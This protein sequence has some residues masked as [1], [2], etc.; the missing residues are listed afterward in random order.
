MAAASFNLGLDL[1][2]SARLGREDVGTGGGNAGDGRSDGRGGEVS[3]ALFRA[4]LSA[5]LRG[6]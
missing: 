1:L 4:K 6:G 2:S 3:V 5:D